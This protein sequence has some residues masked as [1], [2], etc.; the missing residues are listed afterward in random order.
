[1]ATNS[2]LGPFRAGDVEIYVEASP[3]PDEV[4]RSTVPA[5][6]SGISRKMDDAYKQARR[7]ISAIASDF[8]SDLDKLSADAD[9]P[10]PTAAEVEFGMSFGAKLDTWIVK[11]QGDATFKVTIKWEA[12]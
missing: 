11:S 2:H 10:A 9:T 4:K 1:M 5:T 8:A 12:S 3:Q 6:S 7:S